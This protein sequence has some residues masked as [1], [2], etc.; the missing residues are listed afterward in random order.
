MMAELKP[1]PFCGSN[2]I[3][4]QTRYRHGED[5]YYVK[6]NNKDCHVIPETYENTEMNY[7]IDLWN[8]RAEDGK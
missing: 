3:V 1:C 2:A 7:V 6:C 8:R 4:V 5:Y